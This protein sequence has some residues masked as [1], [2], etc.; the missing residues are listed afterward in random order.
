MSKVL[1]DLLYNVS[2]EWVKKLNEEEVLIGISEYA[3]EQLG[4]IVFIDL[5]EE[6]DTVEAG[7]ELK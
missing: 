2:H 3:Q 1:D 5:P 7:V 4:D 6:G